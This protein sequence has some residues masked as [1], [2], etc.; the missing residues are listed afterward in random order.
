MKISYGATFL[1]F[2]ITAACDDTNNKNNQTNHEI[3]DN[4]VDDDGD[5]EIDCGDSDCH[6]NPACRPDACTAHWVFWNMP[7]A[8]DTGTV[9]A[10]TGQGEEAACLDAAQFASGTYY[11]PC[12]PQGQCPKGSVC[13]T[14][15]YGMEARCMVSCGDE[16][17]GEQACPEGGACS[18]Q[19][20]WPF[21]NWPEYTDYHFCAQVDDCDPIDGSGCPDGESCYL[22]SQYHPHFKCLPTGNQIGGHPCD[23]PNRCGAG[24]YCSG[25][26]CIQVCNWIEDRGCKEGGTCSPLQSGGIGHCIGG[27]K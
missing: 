2:F 22:L 17:D 14:F 25:T 6:E 12:G 15:F 9:C 1:L 11:D 20:G 24:L 8:C 3:C 16:A 5:G 26:S 7:E 21:F 19:M 27:G 10:F 13:Q 4:G 23:S 18:F